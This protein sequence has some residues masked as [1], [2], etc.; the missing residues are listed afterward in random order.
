[1]KFWSNHPVFNPNQ[2]GYLS[3]KSTVS[4]LLLS[5]NDW[6][7]AR[8]EGNTTDVVFLDFAKAFDSVPHER[9]LYKLE[10]YGIAGSLLTWF[11]NFLVGR[12][13]RVVVRGSCSSWSSIKSGVPQSTIFGP[14]L[15]LIYI[16]DLPD[17]ITSVIRLFADDTE[18]YRVLK[19]TDGNELQMDLDK[20]SNWANTWQLRFNSAKCEVMRIT[21]RQ[22]FSTPVYYLSAKKLKVV[23]QFKDLGII[24]SN[25]LTWSDQ[26]NSV[27]NK[28]NRVLGIIKRTVGTS[29]MKVFMLLYKTLVRPILEYAVPMWSPY[30]VKDVK[31][32]ESVQRRASRMALNQKRGEMP[33]DSRC[34][35]LKLDTL[36][37][38]RE[39]SS[40][41][42][43]YKTVYGLNGIS[44][45]EVFEF[46]HIRKTRCNHKY[47]LYSKLSRVNCFQHSF[48]VRIIN[49]WNGLSAPVA[50]ADRL[51]LFK[52][53][54]KEHMD[55][56]S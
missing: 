29:N 46:R 33:Y 54:L 31:A 17:D 24:I 55:M 8:N 28:A 39:Y 10:Q 49:L 35:I 6:A 56:Y 20:M 14:I 47:T 13:Q 15:F 38:R 44:F 53:R 34:E 27:V 26:V 22:D 50:E 37:K 18:V 19:D 52:S 51:S 45:D 21:H 41:I 12:Q 5:Y 4:Q 16:N 43:C 11:K 2:F 23:N 7:K 9:L 32:L 40:L 48:F 25:H 1:M 42:E 30:L 36:Q 3:Q